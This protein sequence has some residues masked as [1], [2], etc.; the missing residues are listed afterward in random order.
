MITIGFTA[1]KIC[2]PC[3][4]THGG[5]ETW[6]GRIW[7]KYEV[8]A[9]SACVCMLIMQQNLENVFIGQKRVTRFM[10]FVHGDCYPAVIFLIHSGDS[11]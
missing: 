1:G 5:T 4:T 7:V 10:C 8:L 2:C 3:L 6:V 9:C 11:S